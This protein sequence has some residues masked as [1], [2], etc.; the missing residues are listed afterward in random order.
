MIVDFI[1]M[2]FPMGY[3]YFVHNI[4]ISLKEIIAIVLWPSVCMFT[5]TRSI[6]REIMRMKMAK[7]LRKESVHIYGKRRRIGLGSVTFNDEVAKSAEVQEKS[8]PTIVRSGLAWYNIACGLCYLFLAAMQ[9]RTLFLTLDCTVVHPD[10]DPN[11]VKIL[12]EGCMVKTPYCGSIFVQTCNCAVLHVETHNFTTLPGIFTEMDALRKVHITDGPLKIL[13]EDTG[14][15]L[16]RLAKINFDF[17]RLQML[18]KSLGNAQDLTHLF[19]SFNK[20]RK[21]PSTLWVSSSITSF[22][23]S[24]NEIDEIPL[25]VEMAHLQALYMSNN[26]I[27]KIPPNLFAKS[28]LIRLE[29][30]GNNISALPSEIQ[31]RSGLRYL[32]LARNKLVDASFPTA[33]SSLTRLTLLDLRNNNLKAVPYVAVASGSTLKSFTISGNPMCNRTAIVSNIGCTRKDGIGV[34]ACPGEIEKLLMKV[35][36]RVVNGCQ[37]QCSQYCLEYIRRW[38]D[39]DVCDYACNSLECS[40]DNGDCL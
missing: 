10:D 20:L 1:C 27:E 12:Y 14:T 32:H 37:K 28:S 19:A 40:F 5:K 26:S 13:P 35:D 31:F 7:Y 23:L 2:A 33:M 29:I 38:P 24:S 16:Y 15:K 3:P 22:D 17:N 21:A 8:F 34:T 4:S 18:P 39:L 36:N 11:E 6:F 9:L 25:N 30:D